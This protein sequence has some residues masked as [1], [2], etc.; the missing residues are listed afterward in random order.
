MKVRLYGVD[1]G[2]GSWTRVSRGVK[3]GLE[4]CGALASFLDVTRV[5]DPSYDSLDEGYDASVGLTIGP[6]MSASVMVGRGEHSERLLMIASNSSWLPRNLMDR[7]GEFVTGYVGPSKFSIDVIRKHAD[8]E[9][10]LYLYLHGVDSSFFPLPGTRKHEG[11]SVLHL[12]STHMQRKGTRELL[13]AWG[14]ALRREAIPKDST[15]R[16]VI[17]GPRD[18]FLSEIHKATMG[19]IEHANTIVVLPRLDL[20]PEELRYAYA[21]HHLVAQPSRAEGFG[22]V[23]LEAQACGVPVLMTLCT[24]HEEHAEL[25]V[26]GK[27]II[28]D[29]PVGPIDD[30]PGALAPTV[31]PEDICEGLSVA[32]QCREELATQAMGSSSKTRDWWSWPRVTQDFLLRLDHGKDFVA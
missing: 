1:R 20:S 18:V 19:K 7:S 21:Q 13:Y 3:E 8:R 22:M 14:E 17:D 16:L 2:E 11:W 23:P 4:A 31:S 25:T 29:G 24:G 27:V 6:P 28:P 9:K 30:G 12:A 26:G 5:D 15:L 32:Y 10:K